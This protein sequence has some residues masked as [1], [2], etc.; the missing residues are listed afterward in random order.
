VATAE[1]ELITDDVGE[2]LHRMERDTEIERLLADLKG[3]RQLP[4]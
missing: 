4:G 2:R 1:V 3:R